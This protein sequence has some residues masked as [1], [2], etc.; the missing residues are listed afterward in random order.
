V[1]M[2]LLLFMNSIAVIIRNKFNKRY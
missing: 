2:A 1:L